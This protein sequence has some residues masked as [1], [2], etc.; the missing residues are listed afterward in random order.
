M[1]STP[2]HTLKSH[3]EGRHSSTPNQ[4]DVHS[5][6]FTGF[7]FE[8][9]TAIISYIYTLGLQYPYLRFEDGTGDAWGGSRGSCHT[10]Y[11][12]P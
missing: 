7:W 2:K 5:S 1:F 8:C 11:L 9:E 10:L 4:M 12:E 3:F 6:V